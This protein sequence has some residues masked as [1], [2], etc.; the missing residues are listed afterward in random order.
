VTAVCQRHGQ[1]AER[2]RHRGGHHQDRWQRLLQLHQPGPGP[3]Q[4][5]VRQ[6]VGLLL[7]RPYDWWGNALT[8]SVNQ[9]SYQWTTKDAYSNAYDASDSDVAR[10]S[11]TYYN[12]GNT[13]KFTLVSGEYD[14]TLDAGICPIVIDLDGNGIQTISR[15]NANGTF[16]LLGTG[17]AVKSGWLSG[18]DGF[19]AID[20]NGNG[21]IDD[22]SELFGGNAVG[23]GFAKL[24]AFDSNG[25]GLVDRH[26]AAFGELKIWWTPT[27]TT[28]PTPAS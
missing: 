15:E 28:R 20:S 25:D 21:R 22:I 18:G 7:H 11:S 4:P 19:L 8:Q 26:D 14:N 9:S 23:Q 24:S 16:D 5:A 1:A 10:V 6:V 3:V 2:R 12:Q 13:D 27:A 17:V